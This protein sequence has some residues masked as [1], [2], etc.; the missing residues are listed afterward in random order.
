MYRLI[1]RCFW[2][3]GT[4]NAFKSGFQRPSMSMLDSARLH[5]VE[6]GGIADAAGKVLIQH[7]CCL[8]AWSLSTSVRMVEVSI[9]TNKFE[10][11]NGSAGVG[12]P[13]LG[14]EKVLVSKTNESL[15][16]F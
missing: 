4:A 3:V 8:F 1:R 7:T 5:K 16:W 10:L 15:V 13:A 14:G 12:R 9:T 11:S 6:T 2:A